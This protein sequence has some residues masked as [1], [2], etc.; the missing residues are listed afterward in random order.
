ME[1]PVERFLRDIN[2]YTF[3]ELVPAAVGLASLVVFTRAFSTAAFGRYALAVTVV[4]VGSTLLYGW[5]EQGA[6]RYEAGDD[7]Q[8]VATVNWGLGVVSALVLAVGVGLYPIVAPRLGDYSSFYVA[9][10]ALL[11]LEGVFVTTKAVYQARLSSLLVTKLEVGRA[12]LKLAFALVLSL[13]VLQDIVGWLW[14]GAVSALLTLAV[15]SVRRTPGTEPDTGTLG[16]LFRFGVPMIGWLLGYTLLEFAD[17]LVLELYRTSD[18]V[19]VYAANYSLTTRGLLLLYAPLV[20]AAHPIVMNVWDD[21]DVAAT[22]SLIS[23]LTRYALLVGVP[24]TVGIS[25]IARPLSGLVF[26]QAF[27]A[28]AR[29]VPFAA[30][31]VF[32]WNLGMIGHKGLEIEERTQLLFGGVTISV[33]CNLGLN[34]LLVPPFGALGAAVATAVGFGLYPV[35]VYTVEG[36]RV[37]WRIPGASVRN[38]VAASAVMCL[39]YAVL[40]AN[41][42]Y[43]TPTALAAVPVAAVVYLGSLYLTG[44]FTA[45][46]LA[47]AQ[48]LVRGER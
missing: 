4:N 12:L 2:R 10:L 7:G 44:E 47:A 3:A 6:L 16:R 46:E 41:D 23:R 40:R 39:P 35:F 11:V 31:G 24:S 43:A 25:L 5:L 26:E 37:S 34:L 36:G 15:V 8:V 30:V 13:V 38:A 42:L 18:V 45:A 1:N 28:G 21:G 33:V 32:A 22:E 17:R 14:A 29:I 20:Q 48:R 27:G 19:G 9:A